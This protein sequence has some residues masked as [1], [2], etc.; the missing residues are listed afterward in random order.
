MYNYNDNTLYNDGSLM[1]EFLGGFFVGFFLIIFAVAILQ[2]VATWKIFKKAGKN[3]WESIIPI[4][5]NYVLFEIVGMKGWYAFLA[6]VPFVGSMISLVLSI[7]ANMKL[8]TVFGKDAAFGIGLILVPVIF[9][10]MLAFGDSKYTGFGYGNPNAYPGNNTNTG[11]NP[12]L[13]YPTTENPTPVAAP[14]PMKQNKVHFDPPTNNN[15]QNN[16]PGA[17]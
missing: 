4:Y 8:A 7:M 17:M 9:Y 2:L 15:S 10:P 1:E 14:N 11:Y 3:G 12:N 5:S 6:F 16:T 13:G